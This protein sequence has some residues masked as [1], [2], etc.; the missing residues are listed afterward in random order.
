M[1]EKKKTSAKPSKF[2]ESKGVDIARRNRQKCN[3]LTNEERE[4]LTI[5]AMQLIYG[6][7]SIPAPTTRG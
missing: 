2:P 1:S 3:N 6:S 4:A 7:K 5:R